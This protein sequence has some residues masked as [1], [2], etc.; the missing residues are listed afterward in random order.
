MFVRLLV[1]LGRWL[2]VL[3]GMLGQLVGGFVIISLNG[4]AE[5][6]FQVPI[7]VERFLYVTLCAP[8]DKRR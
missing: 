7:G 1:G 5:L 8:I 3:L 4:G 2:A 6:H